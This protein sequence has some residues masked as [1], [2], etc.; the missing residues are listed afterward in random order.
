VS[1][2]VGGVRCCGWCS[3]GAWFVWL[4]RASECIQARS[5]SCGVQSVVG[6]YVSESLYVL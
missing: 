4:A 6:V 1:C 3:V 2:V 5:V